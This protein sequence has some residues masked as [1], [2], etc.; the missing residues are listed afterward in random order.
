[1]APRTSR[2]GVNGA[3]AWELEI[4]RAGVLFMDSAITARSLTPQWPP[5]YQTEACA[6]V[7]YGL[8]RLVGWRGRS[9]PLVCRWCTKGRDRDRAWTLGIS[10]VL[11]WSEGRGPAGRLGGSWG[12]LAC[13]AGKTPPRIS[14]RFLA[15][16]SS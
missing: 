1:M 2:D 6:S 15:G 16:T 4:W 13:A 8:P 14:A 10:W 5:V 11:G 9:V 12:H 7:G 3:V